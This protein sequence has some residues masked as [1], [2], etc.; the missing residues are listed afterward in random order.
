MLEGAPVDFEHA[1]NNLDRYIPKQIRLRMLDLVFAWSSVDTALAQLAGAAFRLGTVESAI[2]FQ[3]MSVSERL[4]KLR[5]LCLQ[6]G[7]LEQA[8][9]IRRLKNDYEIHSSA[10][11]TIAHGNCA[12]MY[13]SKIVFL[14]YEPEGRGKLAIVMMSIETIEEKLKWATQIEQEVMALLNAVGFWDGA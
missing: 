1:V 6:M 12:G 10:R 7:H 4:N 11:N 5:Q 3:R 13:G 8:K 9:N 14:P 2:V